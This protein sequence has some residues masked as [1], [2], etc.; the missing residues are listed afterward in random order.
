MYGWGNG[1]V[2]VVWMTVLWVMLIG[3][4][5]AVVRSIAGPKPGEGP[6]A[7]GAFEILDERYARGEISADEYAERRRVLQDATSG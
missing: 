5:Y 3:G 1:W 2:G 7:R 4:V 6:R